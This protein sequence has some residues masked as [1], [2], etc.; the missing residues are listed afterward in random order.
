MT[1]TLLDVEG[2]VIVATK[3]D[4]S[5]DLLRCPPVMTATL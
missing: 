2:Q 5:K 1:F 3:A 4:A